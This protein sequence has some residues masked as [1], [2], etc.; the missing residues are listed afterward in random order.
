[1]SLKS[2]TVSEK[3]SLIDRKWL[4]IPSLSRPKDSLTLSLNVDG[5][6]L[7]FEFDPGKLSMNFWASISVCDW[8]SS[9]ESTELEEAVVEASVV[10]VVVEAAADEPA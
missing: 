6:L 2:S 10:V 9:V 3:F 7:L 4:L 1:M 8:G 5:P